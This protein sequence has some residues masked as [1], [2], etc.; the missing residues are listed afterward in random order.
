M[1]KIT[2]SEESLFM[3]MNSHS[4]LSQEE[5]NRDGTFNSGHF[6]HKAEMAVLKELSDDEV[7]KFCKYAEQNILRYK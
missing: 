6:A 3:L 1:N 2:I 4:T 7:H 5:Y